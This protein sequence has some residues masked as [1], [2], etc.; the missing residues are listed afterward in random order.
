MRYKPRN[1]REV[2]VRSDTTPFTFH[3]SFMTYSDWFVAQFNLLKSALPGGLQIDHKLIA[4]RRNTVG[5]RF[6]QVIYLQLKIIFFEVVINAGDKI[7][8]R[9][10]C[11]ISF[12]PYV[13]V[14]HVETENSFE[15]GNEPVAGMSIIAAAMDAAVNAGHK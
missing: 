12:A 14:E 8:F 1:K 13:G 3:V 15:L 5:K 4:R 7:S 11:H 6:S 2:N 10:V 9:D